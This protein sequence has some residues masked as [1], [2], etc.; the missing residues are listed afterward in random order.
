MSI[1]KES[2]KKY[3]RDQIA[4]REAIISQ[5]NKIN[6]GVIQSRNYLTNADPKVI[7]QLNLPT[8]KIDYGS[9]FTY[10]AN[11]SCVIRMSSGVDLLPTADILEDTKYERLKDL[12]G[13]GLATRYVL[14]GGVPIKNVDFVKTN[15]KGD[16]KRDYSKYKHS[17]RGLHLKKGAFGKH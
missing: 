12:Q 14:E 4:L 5:G 9:F 3:V 16:T 17:T 8:N 6:Q 2:F 1:F 13:P 10:T 7:K 11:R 15:E